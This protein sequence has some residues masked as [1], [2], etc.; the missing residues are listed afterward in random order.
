MLGWPDALFGS[1]VVI[2]AAVVAL[3]VAERRAQR[4]DRSG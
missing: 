4:K 1:V 3:Y 2:C